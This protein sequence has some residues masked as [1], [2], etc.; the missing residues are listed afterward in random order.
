[1]Y[2]C[3]GLSSDR[4]EVRA[5]LTPMYSARNGLDHGNIASLD[6]R[7]RTVKMQVAVE[8]DMVGS[9][10]RSRTESLPYVPT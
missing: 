1:M 9:D 5:H 3:K 6:D 4:G 8:A 10:N 7:P 2:R